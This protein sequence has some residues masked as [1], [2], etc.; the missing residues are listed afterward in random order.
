MPYFCI[1]FFIKFWAKVYY[2]TQC[3][4]IWYSKKFRKDK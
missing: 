4:F 3:N 2:F 1:N